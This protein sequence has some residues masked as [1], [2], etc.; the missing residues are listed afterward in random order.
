[1]LLANAAAVGSINGAGVTLSFAQ[2]EIRNCLV[3]TTVEHSMQYI[4]YRVY[5]LYSIHVENNT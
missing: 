3:H 1:M 2:A 5:K 4:L